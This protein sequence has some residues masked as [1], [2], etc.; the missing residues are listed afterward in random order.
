MQF[1]DTALI[2]AGHGST[3]NAESSRSTRITAHR[4]RERGIFGEVRAAFWKEQPSYTDALRGLKSEKAVVVPWFLANGY[5]TR[6][7][8]TREFAKT[9]GISCRVTD[10]IGMSPEILGHLKIRAA[11]LLEEKKWS[12]SEVSLLVA[13]HGTPLHRG[14][15]A[16]ASELAE[17]LAHDGYQT[18]RAVFLEEEPRISDWRKV[19]GT[20]PVVVLPHFLSGGLH[21]SEDVPGLL[22]IGGSEEGWYKFEDTEIGYG[23]TLGSPDEMEELIIDLALR[24]WDVAGL[25]K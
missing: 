23:K 1:K 6:Q 14:S 10:P 13:S 17:K 7:V 9:P 18:A 15:R 24:A 3:K 20:G 2:L 21:G 11:R 25:S 19:A 5:F 16:A 22:G 4:I 8:L 12:P